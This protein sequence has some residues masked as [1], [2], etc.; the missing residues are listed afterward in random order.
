MVEKK[1]LAQPPLKNKLLKKSK[2][3]PKKIKLLLYFSDPL[4]ILIHSKY[5]NKSQ[6]LL[7]MLFL[8]MFSMLMLEITS[9][10]VKTLL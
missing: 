9:N 10:K 5:L 1:K 7:M 4:L 2:P 3:S 8:L 6:N